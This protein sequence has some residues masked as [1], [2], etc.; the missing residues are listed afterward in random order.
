MKA[1]EAY[2][3]SSESLNKLEKGRNETALAAIHKQIEEAAMKGQFF[4]AIPYDKMLESGITRQGMKTLI[5]E[6]YRI[7]YYPS[8]YDAL[9]Y[10]DID[11]SAAYDPI[12]ESSTPVIIK[13]D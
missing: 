13:K 7:T 6:G 11:W 12:G 9:R 3:K 5:N 10:W 1:S 8:E 2:I 4:I